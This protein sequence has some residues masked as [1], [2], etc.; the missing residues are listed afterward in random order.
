MN[1]YLV[2]FLIAFV[3]KKTTK[4]HFLSKN[5]NFVSLFPSAK[6]LARIQPNHCKELPYSLQ[7]V[8]EILAC[9]MI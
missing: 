7:G 6:R 9:L 3:T 1:V 2:V 5:T 8:N 4:K